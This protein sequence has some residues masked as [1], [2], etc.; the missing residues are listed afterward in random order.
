MEDEEEEGQEKHGHGDR[1]LLPV[2]AQQEVVNPSPLPVKSRSMRSR[3]E[4]VK[5]EAPRSGIRSLSFSKLFSI[6]TV[7]SSTAMEH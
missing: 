4:Q 6:R 5:E 1:P 2:Y 7:T 3:A